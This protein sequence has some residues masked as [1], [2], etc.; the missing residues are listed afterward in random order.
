MNLAA[1]FETLYIQK[2]VETQVV[3]IVN[4]ISCSDSLTGMTIEPYVQSSWANTLL[5]KI[6]RTLAQAESF[7]D[8]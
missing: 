1:A 6:C 8:N 2:F 7:F 4:D 3:D 5:L